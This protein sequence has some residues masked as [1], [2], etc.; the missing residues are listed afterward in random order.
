MRTFGHEEA[1]APN[2]HKEDKTKHQVRSLG[3]CSNQPKGNARSRLGLTEEA[4]PDLLKRED[5]IKRAF[6]SKGLDLR[7]N[8]RVSVVSVMPPA[9]MILV[10]AL[11]FSWISFNLFWFSDEGR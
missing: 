2:C 3:P 5:E 4:V 8:E 1:C 7:L 9:L 11:E 10:M 6:R